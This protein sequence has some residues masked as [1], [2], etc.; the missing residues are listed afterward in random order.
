MTAKLALGTV[1]FGLPYGVTN[2]DGQPAVSAV[3][4]TLAF[5]RDHEISVLDTAHAYGSAEDVLGACL[6][7]IG[8]VPDLV[9]KTPP[10]LQSGESQID[11]GHV[12]RA[13]SCFD[14]SLRLL[15]R[16]RVRCM[17]FHRGTD[18]LAAGGDRLWDLFEEL[19]DEGRVDLIGSSVYTPQEAEALLARYPLKVIQYPANLYDARFR[20]SGVMAKL[21]AAGV[22]IHVRSL[23][24]QGVLLSGAHDLPPFMAHLREHHA[25][26][27]RDVETR[28]LTRAA[29]CL[30]PWLNDPDVAC[31]VVGCQTVA[32]LSEIVD[33]ARQASLVSNEDCRALAQDHVLSDNRILNPAEWPK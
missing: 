21:A 23:F 11:I 14:E 2:L 19:R 31:A 26:Y 15:R 13:R 29:A 20:A 8:Y 7:E 17:M 22:E 12:A 33:A 25:D 9:T 1:Q 24:L 28:G 4:E 6:A 3:V 5:A 30:A 27:L 16:D 10:L 18:L 32:Q